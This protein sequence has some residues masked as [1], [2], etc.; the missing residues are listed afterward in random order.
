MVSFWTKKIKNNFYEI[1][2]LS[3]PPDDLLRLPIFR[4]NKNQNVKFSGRAGGKIVL[5][6]IFL[7]GRAMTSSITT[8][9]KTTL[10]IKVINLTFSQTTLSSITITN[11][12]VSIMTYSI[13]MINKAF[14][15]M[16]LSIT[17]INLSFSI[18]T[19]STT[20]IKVTFSIKTHTVYH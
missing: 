9:G 12:T 20:I 13:P 2:H 3:K 6:V 10:R 18:M 15:T 1:E 8:R 17:M 4:C 16:T 19:C 14:A 5:P 7:F 11:V